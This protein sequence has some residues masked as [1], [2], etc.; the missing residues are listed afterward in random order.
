MDK[1]IYKVSFS[2][3]YEVEAMS[4]EEAEEIA[5]KLLD[6]TDKVDLNE[7]TC[8]MIKQRYFKSEK[9][10]NCKWYKRCNKMWGDCMHP[11]SKKRYPGT[12]NANSACKRF[13]RRI[14]L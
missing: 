1:N 8:R 13:E 10:R 4:K 14:N 5:R 9:C 11:K 2:I 12:Y 7:V 6:E 3:S